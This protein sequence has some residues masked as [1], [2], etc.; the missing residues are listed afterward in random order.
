MKLL[1]LLIGSL[2]K[3]IYSELN[4]VIYFFMDIIL[5]KHKLIKT[6]FTHIN[7]KYLQQKC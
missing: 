6:H 5:F 2:N 4:E 1:E 3:K 7:K